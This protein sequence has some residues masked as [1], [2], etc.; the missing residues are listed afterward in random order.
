MRAPT[1]VDSIKSSI[2]TTK[3]PIPMATPISVNVHLITPLPTVTTTATVTVTENLRPPTSPAS[4]T[5]IETWIETTQA[6][7]ATTSLVSTGNPLKRKR[8]SPSAASHQSDSSLTIQP[9]G[10]EP[11]HQPGSSIGSPVASM[12]DDALAFQ[13]ALS[14]APP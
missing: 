2:Y 13:V 1:S 9:S 5:S 14:Y 8:R 12:P 6:A 10:K 7:Q 4:R 3:S 11:A